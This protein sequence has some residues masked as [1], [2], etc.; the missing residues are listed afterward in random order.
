MDPLTPGCPII[1]SPFRKVSPGREFT[2]KNPARPAASRAGRI[3]AGKFSAG[4]D[5]SERT[6]GRFFVSPAIF[7]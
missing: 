6:V 3:F 7:Y 5:F 1:G 4:G 2:G